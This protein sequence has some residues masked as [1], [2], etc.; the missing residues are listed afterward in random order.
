MS[1]RSPSLSTRKKEREAQNEV[2]LK[3][4]KGWW[5]LGAWVRGW[6][7][8]EWGTLEEA[9]DEVVPA[10]I[11]LAGHRAGKGLAPLWSYPP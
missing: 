5:W 1:Q 6:T 4:K 8:G 2:E 3:Q 9:R 10:R 7:R 11:I